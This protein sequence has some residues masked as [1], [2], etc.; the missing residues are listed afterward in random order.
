MIISEG[1]WVLAYERIE[2]FRAGKLQ[3]LLSGKCDNTEYGTICGILQGLQVFEDM[4]TDAR[5]PRKKEIVDDADNED[6]SFLS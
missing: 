4:L 1:M 5:K 3:R 2:T 6:G